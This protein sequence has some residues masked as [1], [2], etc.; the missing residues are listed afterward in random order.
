MT[1]DRIREAQEG[2]L[3]NVLNLLYQLSPQKEGERGGN[4][5]EK[6]K[7][8]IQDS[9]YHLAVYDKNGKII[10]TA[11]L[12]VQRNLSHHGK[13]VGHIENVVTDISARGKGIGKKLISY[14]TEIAAQSNCYK[15][16][17]NCSED[18]SAF[19]EKCGFRRTGEVEMRR[20]FE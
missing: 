15:V 10:G 17:L 8:I 18:N 3:E 1:D 6:Y 2:D 19:Y 16:I 20:D 14:L 4:L 9:N 5:E 11:M 13:P 7:G 12:L